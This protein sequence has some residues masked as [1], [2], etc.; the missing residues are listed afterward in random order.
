MRR[1]RHCANPAKKTWHSISFFPSRCLPRK[2][3]LLSNNSIPSAPLL[4][5]LII[6]RKFVKTYSIIYRRHNSHA[7]LIRSQSWARLHQSLGKTL[8]KSGQDFTKVWARRHQSLGKTL[9]KSGQARPLCWARGQGNMAKIICAPKE[10]LPRS[11][12]REPCA[13]VGGERGIRTPGTGLPR[14]TI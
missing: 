13:F 3:T 9:H 14:T 7:K 4:L 6:T 10:K 8:P 5:I 11:L 1:S 12:P 2:F